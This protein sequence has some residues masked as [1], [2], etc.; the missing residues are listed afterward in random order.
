[1]E[2]VF[3]E[4]GTGSATGNG[5]TYFTAD[6]AT[7]NG[8]GAGVGRGKLVVYPAVNQTRVPLNF[9]SDTESPDPVP[10]QNEVGYPISVQG[11]ISAAEPR[12][13]PYKRRDESRSG[14]GEDT[15]WRFKQKAGQDY[16]PDDV[17]APTLSIEAAMFFLGLQVHRNMSVRLIDF[18]S[19]FQHT[20]VDMPIYMRVP[21]GMVHR[22]GE[23]LKLNNALQGTK[24]AAC[25]F[26]NKATTFLKSRGFKQSAYDP[27]VFVLWEGDTLKAVAVYVDDLRCLA[28]GPDA[29]AQL[30]ALFAD[31]SSIG[32]CK[33][34]DPTNWLGMKIE[35]D[36]EAGTLKVTQQKYINEMLNNFGMTDCKPCRTPAAPGTK[37]VKTPDGEHDAECAAFPYRSLVGALLW[38]ARTARPEIIYAVNQCGAHANNPGTTHIAAS[39]RILRYLKGTAD[40][41]ITFRRNPTGEFQLRAYADEASRDVE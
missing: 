38:P 13:A 1:M 24:Q 11:D 8:Y 15:A 10:N 3:R 29:E 16:N 20:A 22:P 36:R 39:K 34:A 37:L 41:G 21:Q 23:C 32:P 2:P 19:A 30:D 35:H 6:F 28:E 9:F 14:G 26:N 17:E 4:A 5:Y 25:L 33:V 27:C 31:M 40:M 7:T 18:D 12:L